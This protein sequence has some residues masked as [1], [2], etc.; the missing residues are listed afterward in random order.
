M[1]KRRRPGDPHL[2]IGYLRASTSDQ[3]LSPE[4]QRHA[5]EAWAKQHGVRIVSWHVDA[6]VS[7]SAP[8]ETRQALLDALGAVREHGAG[9]L[10]VLRRDRLARDTLVAATIDREAARAGAEVVCTDGGGN[11]SGPSEKF[12]RTVLDAAAE[13]QRA[14]TAANTKAALRA[15]RT[16]GERA[17]EVPFG[18]Q[19]D[20]AG[21]LSPNPD[22]QTIIATARTLRTEGRT[23]RAIAAE[24]AG[25]GFT[26]RTGK[27]LSHTQVHRLLTRNDEIT[28]PHP[29]PHLLYRES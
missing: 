6:G 12:A 14:V 3:R 19:A 13:L 27:P 26:G 16:R 9:V 24:L 20:T 15:K 5:L 2:A 18:F 1:T 4:A 7:G 23:I 8:L 29:S 25:Y 10:L 21:K 17:G 11:G 28:K 22:E